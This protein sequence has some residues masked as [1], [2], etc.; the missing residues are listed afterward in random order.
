MSFDTE[1]ILG[2]LAE[3]TGKGREWFGADGYGFRRLGRVQNDDLLRL[4][5][6]LWM[7]RWRQREPEKARAA[8]RAK[9]QAE[10]AS[11]ERWARR[12]KRWMRANR[13]KR[14]DPAKRQREA[15]AAL[16]KYHQLVADPTKRAELRAKQREWHRR[17]KECRP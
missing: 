13:K 3:S 7:K 5:N 4:A 17:R 8:D 16:A 6:A 1:D 9:Y 2:E 15:E 10:K 14:A 11:Q 12:R